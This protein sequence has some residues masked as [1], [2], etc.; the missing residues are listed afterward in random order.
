[1]SVFS[2]CIPAAKLIEGVDSMYTIVM[3]GLVLAGY[4]VSAK[5]SPAKTRKALLV[6]A[7]SLV[8]VIPMMLG[9]VGIIGIAFAVIPPEWISRYLGQESGLFGMAFA[10]VIGS[11]TLIPGII[12]FPL[13]GSLYRQGASVAT[14]SAFITTLTMVGVLTL[15]AE[16]QHIGRRAALVRNILSFAAAVIIAVLMAVILG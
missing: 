9:I 5:T 4:A 16:I 2:L 15:P 1:M 10:S 8:R 12:A 6:S 7:R 3:W 13:T 14:I 11:I